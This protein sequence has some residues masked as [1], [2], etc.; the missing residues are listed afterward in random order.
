MIKLIKFGIILLTLIYQ[1][2]SQA[3]KICAFDAHLFG[4]MKA[5]LPA[6]METI[7]NVKVLCIKM[8]NIVK[9][10]LII[11]YRLSRSA[12]CAWFKNLEVPKWLIFYWKCWMRMFVY[13]I[14]CSPL[15]CTRTAHFTFRDSEIYGLEMSNQ[16]GR[17]NSKEQIGFYYKYSMHKNELNQRGSNVQMH[18]VYAEKRHWAYSVNI[19]SMIPRIYLKGILL[20]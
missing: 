16:L 14:L 20:L 4:D 1:V 11:L 18:A 10:K 5:R 2:N 7:T 3:L 9:C 12:T 6:A 8:C 17:T 19:T 13:T 15:H